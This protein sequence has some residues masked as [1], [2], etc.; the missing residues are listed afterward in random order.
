M[1]VS[2]YDHSNDFWNNFKKIKDLAIQNGIYVN[3]GTK[4]YCGDV[5]R[6]P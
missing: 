4:N 3:E 5:I 6:D 1:S 2:E